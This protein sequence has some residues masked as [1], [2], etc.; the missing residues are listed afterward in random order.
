MRLTPTQLLLGEGV[1]IL[2]PIP[3]HQRQI[4]QERQPIPI[5][6]EQRREESVDASFRNDVHVEAIAEVD[7][8]D[9]IAFQIAVHD[10]EEDL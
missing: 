8:V 1:Y 9:V 6:Q 3:S 10:G 5:Y 7:G 4:Q 2:L